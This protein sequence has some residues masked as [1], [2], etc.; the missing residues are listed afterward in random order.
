[1]QAGVNEFTL[2][3]NKCGVFISAFRTRTI[4]DHPPACFILAVKCQV[5]RRPLTRVTGVLWHKM[6]DLCRLVCALPV[7]PCFIPHLWPWA[8]DSNRNTSAANTSGYFG[9]SKWSQTLDRWSKI[10]CWVTLKGVW[11]IYTSCHGWI[12]SVNA[13]NLSLYI[14]FVVDGT[15]VRSSQILL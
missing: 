7:D 1:M 8:W 12:L 13:W 15:I 6:A 2:R 5:G 10:C 3:W 9:L 4:V 14:F 11:G